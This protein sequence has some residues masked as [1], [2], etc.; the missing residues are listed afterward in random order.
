MLFD[1]N[2][3]QPEGL[4]G[5]YDVCIAGGGVAGITLALQLAARGRHVLLLEA[6]GVQI[7][8]ESQDVYKGRNT[9]RPYLELDEAQLR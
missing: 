1:L 3:Y 7:S 6:G 9:G 8:D 4:R 2:T 5:E